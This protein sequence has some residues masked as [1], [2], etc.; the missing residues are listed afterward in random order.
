MI[1]D[2]TQRAV[3][4]FYWKHGPC[5]AGCDWWRYF[6]SVLGECLKSAPVTS[7][8]R[9][10]MAGLSSPSLLGGAGHVATPREHHCGDFTDTFDWGSLTL[11]Y[12]KDIDAPTR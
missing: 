10:A 8:Q 3:D 1:S 12:R 6:N 2:P 9:Y 11:A 7:E 5:C 4:A